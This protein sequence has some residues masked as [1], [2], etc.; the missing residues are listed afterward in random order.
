M[1]NMDFKEKNIQGCLYTR[2]DSSFGCFKGKKTSVWQV[3]KEIKGEDI[4]LERERERERERVAAFVAFFDF[5]RVLISW[6]VA[7]ENI[8]G[9]REFL[10]LLYSLIWGGF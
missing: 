2:M 8:G 7:R 3:F 1:T 6:H 9:E 5:E 10:C 4:G